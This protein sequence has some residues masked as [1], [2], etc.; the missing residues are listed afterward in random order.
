MVI[1]CYKLM[2][3]WMIE[4]QW[5]AHGVLMLGSGW[6]GIQNLARSCGQSGSDACSTAQ[7]SGLDNGEFGNDGSAPCSHNLFTHTNEELNAWWRVDFGRSRQTLGGIIWGR[8][9]CCQSRLD[10]F[11]LW[12]GDS[13]TYNGAGNK[14]CYTATTLEHV[15]APYTH[16]FTCFG[17]GRYFFVQLPSYNAL[18]VVE[19]QVQGSV[20]NYEL[21]W[22]MRVIS[23][24][25]RL[26]ILRR[27][28]YRIF[29]LIGLFLTQHP[30]L[31]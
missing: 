7:S 3:T 17:Q 1:G 24:L 18:S 30:S 31:C 9:D 11:V 23:K 19:V 29:R 8:C 12:I 22:D 2:W 25:K 16:A 21:L 26:N 28:W 6:A 10:G 4:Q 13:P 15:L 14:K 27:L 5:H 20:G